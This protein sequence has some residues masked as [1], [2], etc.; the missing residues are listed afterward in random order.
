MAN[1]GVGLKFCKSKAE[2]RLAALCC[3]ASTL[4]LDWGWES[5]ATML[6]YGE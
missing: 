6:E 4:E 5:E 1:P 3:F 2:I